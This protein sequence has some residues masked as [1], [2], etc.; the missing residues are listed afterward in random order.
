MASLAEAAVTA[1]ERGWIRHEVVAFGAGHVCMSLKHDLSSYRCISCSRL[2]V[3]R[4]RSGLATFTAKLE[5]WDTHVHG[6][7]NHKH[8]L[9]ERP[10]NSFAQT[11]YPPF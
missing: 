8:D 2:W 3:P 11:G 1:I 6:H 5:W 10:A 9:F 7:I 4:T